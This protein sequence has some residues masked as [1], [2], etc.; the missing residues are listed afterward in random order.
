MTSSLPWMRSTTELRQPRPCDVQYIFC[1]SQCLLCEDNAPL[2]AGIYAPS[3][4]ARSKMCCDYLIEKRVP[5]YTDTLLFMFV[6]CY[7]AI[8]K[9]FFLIISLN[10]SFAGEGLPRLSS[11]S[12]IF[13]IVFVLSLY[14]LILDVSYMILR[15]V[16]SATSLYRF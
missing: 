13:P 4:F 8:L 2:F 10:L 14:C 6:I 9:F 11:S 3:F 15:C 16:I 12:I 7:S 1:A 5:V